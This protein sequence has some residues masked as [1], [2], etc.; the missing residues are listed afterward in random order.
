M[1]GDLM[2]GYINPH[3]EYEMTYAAVSGPACLVESMQSQ[4]RANGHQI[5][6]VREREINKYLKKN[7]YWQLDKEAKEVQRSMKKDPYNKA[8]LDKLNGLKAN[9]KELKEQ[10]GQFADSN[11]SVKGLRQENENLNSGIQRGFLALENLDGSKASYWRTRI[12]QENKTAEDES[13]R[14]EF[15]NT[16]FMSSVGLTGG[17]GGH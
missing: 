10:A 8:N 7:G 12:A 4:T 3:I 2:S 9:M 15:V 14:T 17:G 13:E 11:R 16:G 5:K 1:D 6:R